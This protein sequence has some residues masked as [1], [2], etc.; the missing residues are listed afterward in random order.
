MTASIHETYLENQILSSA[1]LELIG[2]ML[3]TA[4]RNIS[5]GAAALQ[6]QDAI[7]HALAIGK[8]S[9]IICELSLALDHENGKGISQN[10]WRLYDYLLAIFNDNS[11]R[12]DPEKL[13]I[14][15]NLTA[16]LGDTFLQACK[17]MQQGGIGLIDQHI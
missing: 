7:G 16:F 5:K 14:A 4:S 2:L 3:G 10:L 12:K 13:E 15:A 8:A 1:P 11:A 17:S 9:R 6:S